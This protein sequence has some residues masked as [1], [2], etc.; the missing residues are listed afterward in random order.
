MHLSDIFPEFYPKPKP[1][2][3]KKNYLNLLFLGLL[4]LVACQ[5][6]E[7]NQQKQ[8]QNEDSSK[9][10]ANS[11]D[12]SDT[13]KQS[14]AEALLDKS[15][16]YHDPQGNWPKLNAML[17]LASERPDGSTRMRYV[18][19]D[20]AKG[21]FI[22]KTK[23]DSVKLEQGI[24]ND[25]CF[26]KMNGVVVTDTAQLN[27]YRLQAKRT[28]LMRNYFGYLYGLPMKLKDKGTIIDDQ[29]RKVKFQDKECLSIKVTYEANVGK[30]TWYF[31][32]DPNTYA[33]IGYRFY[34][35]EEEN[36]GEYITLEGLETIQGIKIPK[37]RTWYFNK[38][39]KLLG[40]DIIQASQAE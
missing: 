24:A 35:K 23:Q 8:D 6:N 31:Y 11:V 34:H 18:S 33:L 17:I 40:A 2:S 9:A 28:R 10:K 32:F 16:R 21:G 26:A 36:D 20:N 15:I 38:D 39:D 12:P 13:K 14:P 3:M 27:K 37:K 22:M 25:S 7:Q 19:L 1:K 4:V 29:V 30:D 5:P